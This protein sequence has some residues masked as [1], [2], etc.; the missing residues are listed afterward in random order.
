MPYEFSENST[1]VRYHQTVTL[2]YACGAIGASIQVGWE[3]GS[4]KFEV[5]YLPASVF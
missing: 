2:F 3:G 4:M 5:K 1:F